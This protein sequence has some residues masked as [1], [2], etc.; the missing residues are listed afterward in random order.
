[1]NLSTL[2][3]YPVVINSPQP[4]DV[5]Y[6][7]GA[8]WKNAPVNS[9][10]TYL[11]L[12]TPDTVDDANLAVFTFDGV[13]VEPNLFMQRPVPLMLVLEVTQTQLSVNDTEYRVRMTPHPCTAL[14]SGTNPMPSSDFYW[15]DD[16]PVTYIVSSRPVS[17]FSVT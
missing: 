14:K 3:G 15:T 5:L 9:T 12:G 6:F 10:K 8:K 2:F 11:G 13:P 17:D 7:D 4:G 1:M 16:V